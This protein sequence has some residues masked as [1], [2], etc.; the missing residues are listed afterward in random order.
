MTEIDV[1]NYLF[2]VSTPIACSHEMAEAAYNHLTNLEVFGMGK[3]N[4]D[5]LAKAWQATASFISETVE[6]TDAL[7]DMNT[8]SEVEESLFQ[9]TLTSSPDIFG[10]E[11]VIEL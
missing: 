4:D 7:S 2:E 6:D 11:E 3:K 1:C 10:N 5:V 8:K 9:P